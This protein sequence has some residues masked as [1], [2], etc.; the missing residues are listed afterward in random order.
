MGTRSG[1]WLANRRFD[2]DAAV[3]GLVVALALFPLRFLA[4]QIYIETV[5][6][7]L[8]LA[9]ALY[10]ASAYTDSYATGL[11]TVTRPISRLLPSLAFVGM[12]LMVVTATVTAGRTRPFYVLAGITGTVV[13]LQ[14][15]FTHEEDFQTG[16]YLLEIVAL[17][18][19]VRYAALYTTPG[20]VGI[21]IWTHV[22][23]IAARIDAANSLSAISGNKHYASPLYHLLVVTT[24]MF[25]DVSLRSGLYLSVGVAMPLS[26]LLVYA[27]TV[28]LVDARWAVLA[29]LLYSFGDYFIEWGIHLIPTSH[30]LV[31]FLAVLYMLVRVMQTDYRLRDFA[32]LVFLTVAVVFTHQVSSFIMLVLLGAA[33]LAQLVLTLG[34]FDPPDA[35]GAL[36]SKKPANLF[37][38]LTFDVGLAIFTWSLTP[39][40]RGTFLGTVLSYLQQTIK[41]S[42][43]F[44]NIAQPSAS[45]SPAAAAIPKPTTVERIAKYIDTVGFLLLLLGAFVG[46]LYVVHRRRARHSVFT[47]LLASAL[48]LVFVLGLP[49]FGIR[50]FIPQRWFAFLYAPLAVLTAVGFRYLD[51]E[52]NPR[53]LAVGLLLFALVFPGA[54][55]MSSN[56]TLDNPAF[57]DFQTRVSYTESELAAVDS[58][59]RMTGSPKS[60]NL[61]P[62]EVLYTDQPYQ[63]LYTR[64]GAYPSDM[65]TVMANGTAV[66]RNV[67]VYRRYQSTG[68]P[69]FDAGPGIGWTTQIERERM[70]RPSQAVLYANGNVQLCVDNSATRTVEG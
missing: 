61:L 56:G 62:S 66:D 24:S 17:A 14:V 22:T 25:A 33:L 28:Q 43:G 32:V 57:P 38:L 50:N 10:L 65:A 49:M 34:L 58:I 35:R 70:C 26:V 15:L 6:V 67:T 1:G 12:A 30:G 46:C 60:E 48:M 59:G 52:L 42:A 9:C 63:T 53:V 37:G 54:M 21:D 39:Y 44:M 29:A 19:I 3:I 13:L 47:L 8:G 7:V 31:F 51:A 69:L 16:L 41:E 68:A 11:P 55:V 2:V 23:D 36:G 5:P 18:F 45:S 20:F 40:N 27:A 4:S 64:R